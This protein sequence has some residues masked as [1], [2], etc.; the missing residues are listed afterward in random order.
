MEAI[1]YTAVGLEKMS[2][3]TENREQADRESNHRCHSNCRWIVGLSEPIYRITYKLLSTQPNYLK[4]VLYI[5]NRK[6]DKFSEA[7]Q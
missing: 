1:Y 7:P 2:Q 4:T 3:R 5:G 6:C